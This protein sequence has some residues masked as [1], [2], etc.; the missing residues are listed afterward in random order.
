VK[1]VVQS[2]PIFLAVSREAAR[3][4]RPLPTLEVGRYRIDKLMR[5][6]SS[7]GFASAGKRKLAESKVDRSHA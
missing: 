7:N 4:P 6:Y 5:I 1:I 2:G 3:A